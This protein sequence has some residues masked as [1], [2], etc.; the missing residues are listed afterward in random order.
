M[1]VPTDI[2]LVNRHTFKSISQAKI[3]EGIKS[4]V[5]TTDEMRLKM[6]LLLGDCFS[7]FIKFV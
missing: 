4:N 1:S 3:A 7:L 2:V 6:S 5:K